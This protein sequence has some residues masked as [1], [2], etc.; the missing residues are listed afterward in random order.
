MKRGLLLSALALSGCASAADAGWTGSG[1]TP[2]AGAE[3][4]CRNEARVV[5]EAARPTVFEACMARNGWRR[6]AATR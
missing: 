5:V 6:G 3:Q 1:A 2:F 4:L